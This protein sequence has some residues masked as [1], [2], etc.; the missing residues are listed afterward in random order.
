MPEKPRLDKSADW[1]GHWWLPE[2][3][4]NVVPGVLR[5]DPAGGLGLD[6]IGGFEDRI[7][8]PIKHGVAVMQGS[9][10]WPVIVGVADNKEITLIDC[11]PSHS[12]TY[13]MS[14]DGP[15]KQTIRA[16]TGL[17]GVHLDDI[18]QAVFNELRV[19]VENLGLWSNSSVFDGVIGIKDD[20][21][22]GTGSITVQSVEEPSVTV[23]GIKITLAHEHTLP[24]FD[25]RRGESV[26]RM[27]DTVFVKL[28]AESPYT[29]ATARDQARAIQDLLSLATNRASGL[30]WMQLRLQ[31]EEDNAPNAY[32]KLPRDVAVYTDSV[33]QGDADAHALDH[34][35]VLF[36][37]EH[38]PFADVISRWWKTRRTLHAAS[39]MVLGLRYAPARYLEGNLLTAVGAAE[40]MHRALGM[41]KE[42]IPREEF[43]ALR[44]AL[45]QCTPAEHKSWIKGSVRN[46]ITLRERLRDLASR[47]S[48]EAMARL[49]PDV[50]EWAK[51]STQ[52]RNDL[53]HTGLTARHSI[54]ELVAAVRVTTAVVIMNL[55]QEL[56]V[57]E[58]RQ[59]EV[60]SDNPELRHTAELAAKHL[61]T[62][63]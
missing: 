20:K 7:L 11:W 37:C 55:V 22:D 31:R 53:A 60:V 17:V 61:T 3:T 42:R 26:G 51:V 2:N 57:P 33:V 30:L 62:S 52:A 19:S 9:R 44:E 28:E 8:R 54:D 36:T 35:D 49:V 48:S 14:F 21:F 18:E 46:D 6:L 24:H 45:L 10:S 47:P 12:K 39:N 59:L 58:G 15:H 27:R 13:G 38:V 29:F 16:M 23:D 5:Y 63:S 40:V 41:E 43:D 32:S 50:E 56:G 1:T 34:H 25:R 4:E